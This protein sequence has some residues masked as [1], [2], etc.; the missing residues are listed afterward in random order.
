MST[1]SPVARGRLARRLWWL[2]PLVALPVAVIGVS[3]WFT[4][5][6]RPAAPAHLESAPA[7]EPVAD[8]PPA[9]PEWPAGR[10][11]GDAAKRVLL[12][13]LL[14]AR[15]RLDQVPGYTATFRKQERLHGRLG[16]EQ[17]LAMK[18]R[19]QPFSIYLKFLKPKAGKEVVYAQGAH[20]DHVIAHN[21]DWT[22]RLVPRLKVA[23]T[24]PLALADSRHP[25]T[26]AGLL[27]L[28][29][30]LIEF[31]R[32]D[33]DDDEAVTVLDR[34]TDDPGRTWL[35]SVHSHPHRQPS[36]P[37]Q[38]VEVLYDPET[39]L[40]HKITSF[41]WPEPGDE[42]PLR[43]AECYTYDDVDLDASLTDADFDPANSEYAF[44]R[45]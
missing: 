13:V 4:E 36:R 10:L 39:F 35:R 26:D 20:D 24:D 9:R 3:W 44:T 12:D 27:N 17:T 34:T 21:G 31:R 37:F 5:P 32:M 30:R 28:T 19:H 40:P 16:P 43:L 14:A 33:L 41:D 29:N 1:V 18:V 8:E 42:G 7:P 15:D 11:D 45:F 23:P 38:F 25:V 6:L 2:I 22:R